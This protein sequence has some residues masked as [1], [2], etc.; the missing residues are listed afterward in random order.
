MTI[1]SGARAE[2]L[3]LNLLDA[4]SERARVI[5]NNLANQNTPGFTRRVVRFEDLLAKAFNDRRADPLSVRAMETPDMTS[6]RRQD[7]NNVNPEL[8]ANAG[9]EN[10][11][12]Y[13]AYTAVLSGRYSRL[14]Q[15]I[16]GG[17]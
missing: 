6:P 11:L 12:L 4:S 13:E 8:E 7:G 1:R 2:S 10:R 5:A 15:A 16:I 17:R 3:L 9:R 14:D